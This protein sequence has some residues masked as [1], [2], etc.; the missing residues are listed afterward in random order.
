[1][2]T[3]TLKSI[4]I[5]SVSAMYVN[6]KVKFV[7]ACAR[8]PNTYKKYMRIRMDNDTNVTSAQPDKKYAGIYTGDVLSVIGAF[9]GHTLMRVPN[10]KGYITELTIKAELVIVNKRGDD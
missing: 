4:K 3:I 1:M 6:G 10:K 5:R 7:D 2:I 8:V 9:Q